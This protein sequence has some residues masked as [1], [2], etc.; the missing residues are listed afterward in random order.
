MGCV[1]S[2]IMII[3][4]YQFVPTYYDIIMSDSLRVAATLGGF[5][6]IYIYIYVSERVKQYDFFAR[7]DV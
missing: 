3:R 7:F 2:V 6:D 1:V 5:H 4:A